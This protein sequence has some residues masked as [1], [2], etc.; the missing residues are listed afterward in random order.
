MPDYLGHEVLDRAAAGDR[1]ASLKHYASWRAGEL[2]AEGD[3][4]ARLAS[5]RTVTIIHPGASILTCSYSS[6]VLAALVGAGQAGLRLSVF[7]ARSWDGETSHGER[8]ANQLS[9]GGLIAELVPDSSMEASAR[10]ATLALIGADAVLPD[11]SVVNGYPS[12]GLAEAARTA[13]IPLYCV[14]ETFKLDARP[15]LGHELAIESGF[16]LV[17]ASLVGHLPSRPVFTLGWTALVPPRRN[18]ESIGK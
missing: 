11:A 18:G 9:A 5:A 10:R 16:E 17:P 1:L 13:R 4:A 3:E 14:C 8:L 6:A 15:L 12:R 7:I 2:A